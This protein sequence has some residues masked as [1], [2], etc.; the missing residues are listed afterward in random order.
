[1]LF[2]V[3]D[4]LNDW[5]GALDGHP[6]TR[7]PNIDGLARRGMLFTNAHAAGVSCNP[8]RTAVL[9][10]VSPWRSGIFRNQQDWRRALP[11]V[12]TLPRYFR[13][14]GYFTAGSGKV[15]HTTFPDPDSWDD[16]W[17]SKTTQRPWDPEPEGRPLNGLAGD[18]RFDWG[19]VPV[20]VEEMADARVADWVA[21]Q[22][23]D[24]VRDRPFFLA[25]GI[26]RPHLPWFVPPAYF[27]R[28]EISGEIA[29]PE[30][31]AD[32]LDD[33]SEA[34]LR[35][36][37]P[38]GFHRRVVEAGQWPAAVQA[39]LASVSFADE[40][41]GH[42]LE[43]LERS[44]HSEDTIVVLWSDHGF[45]LGEKDHWRKFTLWERTTRVPLIIVAP[46]GTPG[47]ARG[48]SA[49][50]RSERTVSL[51]DLYRTLVELA[52][53]PAPPA[54]V[55][56]P[57]P[58][59]EGRSLVPLLSD[60]DAPWPHP[61]VTALSARDLSVRDEQYRYIRYADGS[62]ELYDHRT[63]PG[64]WRN[65]A[66]LESSRPVIARLRRALVEAVGPDAV[67]PVG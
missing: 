44:G 40:M 31:P 49:G 59:V 2:I 43:A 60:P 41:V 22:L 47:L 18:P 52:G 27:A 37:R 34:G 33:L 28:P 65:L 51:L 1:M 53:L 57:Y 64:E 32:D 54:E 45:H 58:G 23:D 8:S 48:T 35:I 13:E 25:L 56:G 14:H 67:L 10:G 6:Q 50:A 20:P 62:E 42:V 61:A 29:L 4:D 30:V 66:G 38:G 17:P 9:T 15:F 46:P 5:V 21:R 16:F 24:V 19:P 63:D 55:S 11:G 7:T 12:T 36:A 3:V 26:Y 39:Y